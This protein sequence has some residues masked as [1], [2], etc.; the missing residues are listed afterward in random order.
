MLYI[1]WI[2][3]AVIGT[4]GSGSIAPVLFSQIH[5]IVERFVNVVIRIT[6]Q[7][8]EVKP[9][10][11]GGVPCK[12]AD[13]N[14]RAGALVKITFLVKIGQGDDWVNASLLGAS[15]NSL[16][17]FGVNASMCRRGLSRRWNDDWRPRWGSLRRNTRGNGWWGT[18]CPR[19]RHR[20]GG[21]ATG[22][23]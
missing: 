20:S 1:A 14:F 15:N 22:L 11:P 6:R 18:H 19:K 4:K 7:T 13:A 17:N 21:H 12:L 8:R 23:R 16:V 9:T 5:K 2:T 3:A 10:L